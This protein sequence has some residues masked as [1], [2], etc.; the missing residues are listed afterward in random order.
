VEVSDIAPTIL[1]Y[2]GVP[3]PPQMQATSLKPL[4]EKHGKP[5]ASIFSE[6]YLPPKNLKESAFARILQVYLL[7]T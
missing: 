5:H 6:L 7:G 3:I 2:A 1:E 4:V